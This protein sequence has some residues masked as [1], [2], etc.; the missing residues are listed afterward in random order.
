MVMDVKG[1]VEEVRELRAEL[2][3]IR[4]IVVHGNGAS[5][6]PIAVCCLAM[7]ARVSEVMGTSRR[8]RIAEARGVCWWVLRRLHPDWTYRRIGAEVGGHD[9][10]TVMYWIR[11]IDSEVGLRGRAA[12]ALRLARGAEKARTD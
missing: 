10:T 12:Y 5:S 9:Y 11:K 7:D 6:S 1:L 3:V 8:R 4:G 2:A